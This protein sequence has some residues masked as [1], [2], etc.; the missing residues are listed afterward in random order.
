[1][2]LIKFI[3]SK[4]KVRDSKPSRFGILIG[5]DIYFDNFFVYNFT[6]IEY[7]IVYTFGMADTKSKRSR[8]KITW[9]EEVIEAHNK[10]RGTR[11]KICE[12]DTP[13]IYY[14]EGN[15]CAKSATGEYAGAP[16][17]TPTNPVGAV[18]FNEL[19]K[20]L[21]VTFALSH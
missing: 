16:N 8:P 9:D 11:M 4:C 17:H 6:L 7:F 19:S 13:Y 15:D 20:K 21:E 3:S 1:M 18:D 5:K 2:A 14:N 12:P 10:E